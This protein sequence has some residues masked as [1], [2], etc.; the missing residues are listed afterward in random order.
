[1]PPSMQRPPSAGAPPSTRFHGGSLLNAYLGQLPPPASGLEQDDDLQRLLLGAAP[2]GEAA[3][4]RSVRFAGAS[5]SPGSDVGSG[6][7]AQSAAGELRALR[8]EVAELRQLLL[9]AVGER[10]SGDRVLVT[11]H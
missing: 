6:G 1:M 2:G 10:G 8:Q 3:A 4:Q 7:G 9:A 5:P 11:S